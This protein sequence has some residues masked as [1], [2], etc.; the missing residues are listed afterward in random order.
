METC[1]TRPWRSDGAAV[2]SW[3]CGERGL[4]EAVLRANRAGADPGRD[5]QAVGRCVV[6]PE[7]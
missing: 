5:G 3:L 1:A 7:G 6:L 4:P 2:R